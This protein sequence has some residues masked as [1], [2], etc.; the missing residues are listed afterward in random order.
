MINSLIMDMKLF[1][2][3]ILLTLILCALKLRDQSH[4]LNDIDVWLSR[5]DVI[6]KIFANISPPDAHRGIVVASPSHAGPDYYFHWTR[7]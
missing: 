2:I 3:C 1:F 4:E 6:P 7:E 5:I